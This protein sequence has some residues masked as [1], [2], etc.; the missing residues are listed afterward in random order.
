MMERGKNP[1]LLVFRF[2]AMGDVAMVANVLQ[3]FVEQHRHLTVVMVSRE[4]FRPFF[5]DVSGLI[6]HPFYPHRTH[7]GMRGLYRLFKE[8]KRYTP[9]AVA[10]L[11][12]NIRSRFLSLLF[13]LNGITVEQLD[14]GRK[15]KKALTRAHHK[16]LKPLKPTVERYADVFRNLGY[17]TT[18]SHAL[19]QKR[20]PLPETAKRLF[21]D[22]RTAKVG[23]A[24]FAQHPAKMYPLDRM[25]KVIDYLN[26]QGH[27]V[28]IFGGGTVEQ[29]TA[30]GWQV[31]YKHVHSLIGHFSLQEELAII[32]Q[33][34]VMLSMDSAGMHMA[35]LMGVRV[36]SI[37]GATH[38]YAGF[39]GYGQRLDDCI[40]VEHPARPS[41]IYGDKPCVCDGKD[42]MELID[43][44][45]IINKL[46]EVGL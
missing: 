40:Q 37:W 35:S 22:D 39:L 25:E 16:I 29:Q 38:P 24:P 36:L 26:Q 28:L 30:E 11:H 3:E 9:I 8:L 44:A 13:R 31:K 27:T 6:F 41:S 32:A 1:T 2:S 45:L 20:L 33:L 19:R 42:S 15:E 4:I 17:P 18:L 7:K 14:K 34:D 10:D 12:E 5:S 23:I 21:A 43:P 46:R